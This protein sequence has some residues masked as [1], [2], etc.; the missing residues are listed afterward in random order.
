MAKRA[1]ALVGLGL[2]LG[3]TGCSGSLGDTLGF[4]KRSPDEFAVVKRQPL[5][6]PPDYD[7]RPPDPDARGPLPTRSD[8]RARAA[9]TGVP[10][11]QRVG[12]SAGAA[13][14]ASTA[15]EDVLIRRTAEVPVDPDVRAVLAEEGGGTAP[16]DDELFER[17][18]TPGTDGA[19]RPDAREALS[20]PD[21]S[22]G[23]DGDL[24]VIERT[25]TPLE[26]L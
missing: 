26:D 3:V 11:E 5:I 15:G 1:A 10:V 2:C 4:G 14:A 13:T 6:L 23:A 25:S 20:A 9:L 16:V 24:A 7:L 19:G 21:A 12:A 8:A 22:G 17:L 18:T